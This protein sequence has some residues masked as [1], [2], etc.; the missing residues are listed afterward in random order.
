MNQTRS[1]MMLEMR[2]EVRLPWLAA[3]LLLLAGM[4][5]F[6]GW[7][8][9]WQGMLTLGGVLLGS[10]RTRAVGAGLLLGSVL[11]LSIHT[12]LGSRLDPVLED[13]P[14]LLEGEVSSLPLRQGFGD[15]VTFAIRHCQVSASHLQALPPDKI[16]CQYLR[17]VS[18]SW[19]P[20]RVGAREAG[21]VEE[22]TPTRAAAVPLETLA[23]AEGA[24][25][26]VWPEP[27]QRWRLWVKLR[28]PVAAVNPDAFDMEE[29]LLQQG[30]DGVGRVLRR[31]RLL[32]MDR[33][34]D[35][36]SQWQA[37][38]QA[39]RSDLRRH[40]ERLQVRVDPS[41]GQ[42]GARWVLLGIVTGLSLGDQAAMG[43]DLWG[44]FSRTG[45]SHLMAISGMHV[46]LLAMLVSVGCLWLHGMLARRAAGRG[47]IWLAGWPRQWLVLL[48]AVLTAFGYAVL[49]GWGVPAQRTCFMLLAAA[50]LRVGGRCGHAL[51]PVLLSA[52]AIVVLD[53][54]AMAQAGFWLSFCAVLALIWGASLSL[55]VQGPKA[56]SRFQRCLS[57]CREAVRNQWAA[58]VLLTP[59]TLA[60]FSTWSLI[61]PLANAVAIP[62]VGLVLTPMA[63]A[64][65]LLAPCL[66]WLAG[67]L[68]Q[69]LLLQLGWLMDFLRTL[70]GWS[71]ASMQL[72]RPGALVLG[73]ALLGAVLLTA[74]VGLRRPRLGVLCLLPLLLAEPRLAPADALVVTALDIG[75][76]SMVMLEQGEH[77]LLYDT[78][79]ARPGGRSTL[80]HVLLPW[81][82]SRG[83][84]RVEM[85]VASHLDAQHTGG[86]GRAVSALRPTIL[87]APMA[88]A[89]LGIQDSAAT[90]SDHLATGNTSHLQ[91]VP[92]RAGISLPWADGEVEVFHPQKLAETVSDAR[93]DRNSCVI[94][95]HTSAGSVLLAGDLPSRSE[96]ALVQ[97]AGVQM[98]ADLLII[99]QEGGRNGTG[100]ALLHVV[101]PR[102]AVVQTAYRHRHDHPDPGLL[103]RLHR[104]RISLMRTDHDGAV[105]IVLRAGKAAEI[106]RSRVD[107]APYWRLQIPESGAPES[108]SGAMSAVPS[109]GAA[110]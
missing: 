39:I 104:H 84:N 26:V 97:Q 28:R 57:A 13:V 95:I 23:I 29:R 76:G 72:P 65:M 74:P 34:Q 36:L 22:E 41:H 91:F 83:L 75:Q 14:L 33:Q 108:A 90:A 48:P 38:V 77:R 55:S 50:L 35:L 8:P 7:L 45:V 30:I 93:D 40:L 73:T 103:V 82:G 109:D 59:L 69:A 24:A 60:Y 105:R 106:H 6:S 92:C 12:S 80:D 9:P 16:S 31:Q 78:G 5:Q 70:D 67:W 88:P 68:L 58:T 27:G 63:I 18:L 53:P 107:D 94:R 61:G 19:S 62:W 51:T 101:Q 64:V 15:R 87:L 81:L 42:D 32:G 54:W 99:P 100:D 86:V 89:L 85:L 2:P 17:Q 96:R 71:L 43:A 20:P 66:P 98:A 110:R 49:S 52:A 11:V 56:T 4:V 46:T 44:L 3:C 47:H 21:A 79:P 10:R 37:E 1:S 25:D 102:W